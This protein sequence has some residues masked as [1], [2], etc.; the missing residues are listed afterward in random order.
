L[1]YQKAADTLERLTKLVK[2]YDWTATVQKAAKAKENVKQKKE[3]IA[4]SKEDVA[5]GQREVDGMER[6]KAELQKKRDKVGR[7]M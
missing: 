1:E 2:A 4:E 6:D 5:R 3:A 7:G